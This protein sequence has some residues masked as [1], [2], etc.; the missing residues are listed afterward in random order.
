MGCLDEQTVIAFV[1]GALVGAKLAE[2][3]RHLVGCRDCS[4]LVAI[5]APTT[6]VRK[7]TLERAGAPP[8]DD[9]PALTSL[10]QTAAGVPA[11]GADSSSLGGEVEGL[12]TPDAP[13][14]GACVGRYRLLNL[15]G[16]G[17]MGEVYAAH[18]P[19]LD[20][21]IAIKIM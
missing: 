7:D 18:D 9:G 19:E 21:R 17:G 8:P 13:R 11:W 4:A 14:P 16:R 1:K 2:A 12:T 15:V 5:A 3:E 10:S 6:I 20:R